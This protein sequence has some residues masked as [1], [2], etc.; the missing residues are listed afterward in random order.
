V[1]L[2]LK[3]LNFLLKKYIKVLKI[4]FIR[5]KSTFTDIFPGF[6]KIKKLRDSSLLV[7][8]PNKMKL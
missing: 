6:V 4:K 8:R 3:K 5:A 7:R 1:I 2:F